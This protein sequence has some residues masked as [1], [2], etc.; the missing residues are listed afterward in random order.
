MNEQKYHINPFTQKEFQ[1][2]TVLY[3]DIG[4]FDRTSTMADI[5]RGYHKRYGVK[6][7]VCRK[8][9]RSLYVK[10]F[11]NYAETRTDKN[12]RTKYGIHPNH[13]LLP[14]VMSLLES[15]DNFGITDL[16][17]QQLVVMAFIK[18]HG[19]PTEI[20]YITPYT[21]INTWMATDTAINKGLIQRITK[22]KVVYELT[23][24]GKKIVEVY[25]RINN[26][27]RIHSLQEPIAV[28]RYTKPYQKQ[29]EF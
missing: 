28:K 27:I 25:E 13:H 12:V 8:M 21:E 20:T 23:E 1:L 3:N 19:V 22:D 15:I 9:M 2:L 5:G 16:Q 4:M 6:I 26:L 10:G 18:D 17:R 14:E 24:K 29:L 7:S 11:F